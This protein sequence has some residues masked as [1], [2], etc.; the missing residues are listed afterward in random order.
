MQEM[1]ELILVAAICGGLMR[2]LVIWLHRTGQ[3]KDG[4]IGD[5]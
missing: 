3:M 4:R 5:D 2:G 1:F